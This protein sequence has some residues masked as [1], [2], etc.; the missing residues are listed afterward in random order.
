MDS[1]DQV[2][3]VMWIVIPAVLLVTIG[4]FLIFV[5]WGKRENEKNRLKL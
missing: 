4:G 3:T 2:K 5:R 1:F